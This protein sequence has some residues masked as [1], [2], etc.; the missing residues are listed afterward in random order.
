[1]NIQAISNFTQFNQ[2]NA[3]TT[4]NIDK[5]ASAYSSQSQGAAS[6]ALKGSIDSQEMIQGTLAQRRREVTPHLGQNLDIEA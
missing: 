5:L 1:M 6:G 2:V 3:A 4:P